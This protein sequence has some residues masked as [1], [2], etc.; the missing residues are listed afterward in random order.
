MKVL[1]CGDIH[2]RNDLAAEVEK[3]TDFLKEE[4][5]NSKNGYPSL[6]NYVV[7]KEFDLVSEFGRDTIDLVFT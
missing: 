1:H 6:L 7:K 5:K 3:C 2:F 4:L